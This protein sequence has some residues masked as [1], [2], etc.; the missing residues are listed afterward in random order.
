[1]S[2]PLGKRLIAAAPYMLLGP[3]TG[4]L[5]A[6]VVRNLRKGH[7]VLA[8]LYAVAIVEIMVA[9]PLVTTKLTLNLVAASH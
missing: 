8:G 5:T 3:I 1:V 2:A 4:P 7:P 9:L 6:G